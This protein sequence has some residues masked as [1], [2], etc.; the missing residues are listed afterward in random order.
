MP[1]ERPSIEK[2]VERRNLRT[3]VFFGILALGLSFCFVR[4]VQ[5]LIDADIPQK[6][7]I[8][9]N[10]LFYSAKDTEGIYKDSAKYNN[11]FKNKDNARERIH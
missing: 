6:D 5:G 11:L 1:D 10:M 7:T 8:S 3:L 2:Q 4:Y 9:H